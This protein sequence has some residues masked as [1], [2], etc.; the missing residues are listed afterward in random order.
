MT[1]LRRRHANAY[2]ESLLGY[3]TGPLPI[4]G[5]LMPFCPA[6]PLARH[7]WHYYRPRQG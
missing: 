1:P 7:P 5:L 2:S 3:P 4:A 6:R